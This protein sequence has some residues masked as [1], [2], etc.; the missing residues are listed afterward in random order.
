MEQNKSA[1]ISAKPTQ[2]HSLTLTNRNH[3][4]INGIDKV[5]SVKPDLLQIKSNNGDIVV[6]GQNMEVIKLDLEQ[7]TITLNGKFDSFKYLENTKTP[8][9]KKIFK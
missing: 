2:E 9:L 5:V 6:T 4:T 7:H 1:T 3:L 8:L